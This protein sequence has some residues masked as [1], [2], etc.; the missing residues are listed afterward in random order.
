VI[1]DAYRD[2]LNYYLA[3]NY[4]PNFSPIYA[5]LQEIYKSSNQ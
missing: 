4:I 3:F 5:W 2:P 1:Q